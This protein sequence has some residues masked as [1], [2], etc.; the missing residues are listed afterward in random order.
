MAK[1]SFIL[2]DP[3]ESFGDLGAFASVLRTIKQLGFAGIECNLIA[4]DLASADRLLQLVEEIQLPIVSFLTGA[5]YFS[6][7]LCLSS[8]NVETRQRA[9]ESLCRFT[10]VAAQ[11]NAVL[12]VGQMQ[13]FRSDE[14]HVSAAEARIEDAL[15]QVAAS[16]E[17]NGATVVVEPVNHL[18]CGFHNTLEAVVNLVGRIGSARVRPMLDSFHMN[19]EEKSMT[20]PIRRAGN[21][22]AH[23]HLCES[24]GSFLGSGRL[25]FEPILAALESI[26]YRGFVSVKVYREAWETAA[27]ATSE[28]L[29][30]R[31]LLEQWQLR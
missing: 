9:V 26:D 11:F 14:P 1:F 3:L 16:A 21:N 6:E 8:P 31:G 2:C 15:R 29:R 25:D 19:V 7:G 24:N 23:F 5:N 12:V 13:G 28:H 4:R 10:A 17:A 22:L 20:E 18:Q 27:R 30:S